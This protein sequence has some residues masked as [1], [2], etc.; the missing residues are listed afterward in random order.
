MIDKYIIRTN[1]GTGDYYE[2]VEVKRGEDPL[3][4]A[5]K[6]WRSEAEE[7]ADYEAVQYTK[8]L[9]EKLGLK[10]GIDVDPFVFTKTAI[11]FAN[12]VKEAK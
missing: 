5:Y 11:D 7:Y 4:Y 9:A 12:Y 3:E 1:I 6:L 10:E 2:I 8:E